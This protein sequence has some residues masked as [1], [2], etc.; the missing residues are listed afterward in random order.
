MVQSQECA[1]LLPSPFFIYSP[2][3]P[4]LPAEAS[5]DPRP[6]RGDLI[7]DA[8]P[9]PEFNVPGPPPH[10]RFALFL[11]APR[12]PLRVFR[13][14][15]ARFEMRGVHSRIYRDIGRLAIVTCGIEYEGDSVED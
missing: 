2:T 1:P 6:Q 10:P 4:P 12:I 9:R 8:L 11:P 5:P 7:P 13:V 3:D 14:P 15:I